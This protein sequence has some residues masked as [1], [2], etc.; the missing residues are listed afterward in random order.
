DTGGELPSAYEIG[1]GM[2]KGQGHGLLAP[3]LHDLIVVGRVQAPTGALAVFLAGHT[4]RLNAHFR[5]FF[6]ERVDL[7]GRNGI[8]I[9]VLFKGTGRRLSVNPV[10]A[11]DEAFGA[12]ISI[13]TGVEVNVTWKVVNL[14]IKTD[15]SGLGLNGEG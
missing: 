2:G 4:N 14:I 11:F 13:G 3:L 7:A 5:E 9:H 1:L 15:V 12:Q 10:A 8:S 6:Y